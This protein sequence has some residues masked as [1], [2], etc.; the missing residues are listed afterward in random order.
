MGVHE[1]SVDVGLEV[2]GSP[3]LELV[4]DH[5]VEAECAHRRGP[6]PLEPRREQGAPILRVAPG[7]HRLDVLQHGARAHVGEKAEPA[8]IHPEQRHGL[9][10]DEPRR[11]QE[12]AVAADRDDELGARGERRFGARQDRVLGKLEADAGID[13]GRLAAR[14]EVAGEGQHALGDAQILGVSNQR[15]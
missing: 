14:V 6:P 13:Q 10:G 2:Q 7:E 9:T 1:S 11:V 15:D 8:A 3:G 4:Q 12:R 5:I